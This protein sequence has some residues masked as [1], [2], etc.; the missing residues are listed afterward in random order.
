MAAPIEDLEQSSSDDYY[1]ILNVRREADQDELK[2]AY[3]RMCMLYHPD[4]HGL[5]ADKETAEAIFN[6]VQEAYTVL[7]DPTK[8]AIYDVYGKKGLEAD[9]DLV[10]RTRSPREIREEFERLEKLREERRLQQST[11]PRGVI[12]VGIDATDVFDHYEGYDEEHSGVP[13]IEIK[14]MSISQ[15]LDAPLNT[16]DTASF[17]GNLVTQ[18][19]NGQGSITGS[20]RRVTSP[21]SWGELQVSGGSGP[22]FA[23][24]YFRHITKRSFATCSGLFQVTRTGAVVP[25][26]VLVGARQL[27]RNTMGYLTWKAGLQS[28]MNSTVVRD[29]KES[30]ISCQLQLGIPNTFASLSYTKKFIESE[31]RMTASVKAGAFGV[32]LEYGGERKVSK[33]NRLGAKMS[34]GYPTGVF[35]RLRASRA[36][37]TIVFPIHLS[38]EISPQAIFYGTVAPLAVYWIIKVLV[39]N[40]YLQK[41]KENDVEEERS[42]NKD[43]IETKKREAEASVR[44][45]AEMVR[46]IIEFETSREGL[47]IVQAWYGKL[48]TTNGSSDDQQMN[49]LVIDVKIPLQCQV[50]DSKLILTDVSKSSLPG[51]YDPCPGEDKQLKVR[52]EFRQTLH[53]CTIDDPEQLRIPRQSHKMDPS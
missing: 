7:N 45:M 53:E 25:G 34:V 39:V 43:V 29:A 35:L 38:Q 41:Q 4:K 40:P 50:K 20:I 23:L 22:S 31:G 21:Q 51:F 10:P 15:S 14:S 2:A 26:L 6:N 3:R 17:S 27:D 33:N 36:N 48:I 32:L 28:S 49:G 16:S 1:A 52:Y 37:Q 18:N 13:S 19:G 8:R 47:I 30:N 44:L 5:D 9:W 46:R 12:L 24:K 11:N 42:R